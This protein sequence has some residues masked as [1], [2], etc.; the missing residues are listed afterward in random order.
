MSEPII[1]EAVRADAGAWFEHHG[2]I[3]PK[4]RKLGLI[5]PKQN[6]LQRR[7]QATVNRFE[8]L[9]LPI[10][11]I[12][13]KPRQKGSTTYFG[14]LD[15]HF[16]RRHPVS[17]C[18][19]GGQYDQTSSLWDMF[20]T[21]QNN[22]RF[23]WG[24][25]GTINEAS[26]KWTNGS[27]L[28]KETANDK[29]AGVSDTFQVLHCTEVARWSKYGVRDAATVLTNIMKCVP[30]LPGTAIFEESTAEGNS[31]SFYETFVGA[32][33]AEDFISGAVKVRPGDMV[34]VF[35]AWFE[36]DDSAIPLT[37]GDKEEVERTLDADPEYEGEK[38]LVETYGFKGPD[39][40][41]RLGKAVKD[42]DVWEQLAW[43]RYAIRSECNKD[44]EIFDRDFPHSWETA[45]LKS[46][47]LRFNKAGVANL[48]KRQGN[49][50]ALYGVLEEAAGRPAFRPTD[51]NEANV[52]IYEKPTPG[53]R[54]LCSIDPMTGAS[55]VGGED[56]D[57][58]GVGILRDG[59]WDGEGKWNRIGVV[60]R[61]I[62]NRW[63]IDVV[64]YNAW[65]LARYYGDS[66][67]CKMAIEMNKDA[68]ITEY[69][70][71]KGADL[72]QREMFNQREF[73]MTKAY[74]WLTTPTNRETWVEAVAK[75]IREW[76]TP[77]EGVD[78]WDEHAIVQCE[79]FTRKENGSSAAAEGFHDDD[80]SFIGIG[81]VLIDH[82]TTYFPNR[83]GE[84]L[85]P[86]LAALHHPQGPAPSQYS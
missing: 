27:Q 33:D 38:M 72:Y 31:G 68:G 37:P 75:G 47:N 43:R 30:L 19:I 73:K 23:A 85:P 22:D 77:G 25:T 3:W 28:R 84:G 40:A 7:I 80:I 6:C 18:V 57:E 70:K 15:Y 5:R 69:L 48:R 55:Q 21:Y 13:L 53:K 39:G 63:D 76:N 66:S 67:G 65:M 82:A 26:G 60:A 81:L 44:K 2:K 1:N 50:A 86:D 45:F 11:I 54:Y 52:I 17:A 46:G 64:G 71:G 8:D 78:I 59:F 58:H 51:T 4:N 56:P 12:G 42:F 10:R 35:A 9:D 83:G 16:L 29:L 24:N 14:A 61:L 49:R 74:G 79:N 32:A 20:Q 41:L 36:F 34:R 62:P